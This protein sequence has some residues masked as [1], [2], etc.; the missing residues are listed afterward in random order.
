MKKTILLTSL[1]CMLLFAAAAQARYRD[2]DDLAR[3]RIE[4]Y[5]ESIRGQIAYVRDDCGTTFRVHL[6]PAWYWEDHDYRLY[7]GTY[8]EIVAWMD[9]DEDYCYAGEIRG[10]N[11]CFDL[12]DSYGFPRWSDREYCDAG[13]R[14]TRSFFSIH[15]VIGGDFW[16][17]YRPTY[18]YYRPWYD[19]CTSYH[20]SHRT[21]H[22]RD[23]DHGRDH[24]R[25][26][27]NDHGRGGDYDHRGGRRDNG[28]GGNNYGNDDTR[29]DSRVGVAEGG[30]NSKI[31]LPRNEVKQPEKP[32]TKE[33]VS[34]V[35]IEKSRSSEKSRAGSSSRNKSSYKTSTKSS[36][37]SVSKSEKSYARK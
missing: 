31:V 23:H 27:D 29:Y 30:N 34:K 8:V 14:P 36:R 2:G 11:Y 15:F 7:S 32:R 9:Y 18:V 19:G 35:C 4:G 13:W 28:G 10:R 37:G 26:D 22:S 1:L 6:G 25:W 5:V 20:Y 33:S 21:W 17:C 3:I 12:C 24:G 16:H